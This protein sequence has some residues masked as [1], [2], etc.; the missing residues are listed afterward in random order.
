MP[1]ELDFTRVKHGENI[2]WQFLVGF[3]IVALLLTVMLV[4]VGI[5]WEKLGQGLAK[6]FTGH[7]SVNQA[8][9]R[10]PSPGERLE[11]TEPISSTS[12]CHSD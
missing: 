6:S 4:G 12:D 11:E 1:Q 10:L 8:P 5:E 9:T 3:I 2:V 7:C